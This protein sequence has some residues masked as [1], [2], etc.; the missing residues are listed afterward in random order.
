MKRKW[1]LAVGLVSGT[2]MLDFL[3]PWV[4]SRNTLLE[5]KS[6]RSWSTSR[7]KCPFVRGHTMDIRAIC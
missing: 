6:C 3:V 2:I 1:D 7:A 4:S 5:G